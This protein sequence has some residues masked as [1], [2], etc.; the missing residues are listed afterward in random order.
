MSRE[1]MMLESIRNYF[2]LKNEVIK[3][4]FILNN[5]KRVEYETKK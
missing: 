4:D 1:E 5:G 3:M 2:H